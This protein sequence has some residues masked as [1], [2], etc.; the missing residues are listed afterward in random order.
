LSRFHE[1]SVARVDREADDAVSIT[2]AVPDDLREHYA[3]V[4]GQYVPIEAEIEGTALRRTYS[5][6]SPFGSRDLRVG[7]REVAGGAFSTFANRTLEPGMRLKVGVPMGRFTATPRQ[8][9][10]GTYVAFASGAGITPILSIIASLLETDDNS[11]VTLFFGNRNRNAIMFRDELEDLKDTFLD[12]FTLIHV[13]SRE[14]Q[15]VELLHGRLDAER[16]KTFARLGQFDVAG[17]DEYFL[18][19]P[20]DLIEN[21]TEALADLGVPN[22]KIR[23][24]RFTPAIPAPAAVAQPSPQTD[25]L[26]DMIEIEAR[27]DG[28]THRL[29]LL[30]GDET[31]IDAA[32]R[33]GIE[34]PYS[35]KGGMCCTCRAKLVEGDA[36]MANNYSLQPWELEAGFVLTC[37]LRPRSR[38]I[39]LDYDAV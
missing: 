3:F 9:G 30:P 35:C 27:L 8:D 4:P 21:A 32:H 37:Q 38:R 24:E 12:R 10:G 33:Q 6:C 19:G 18:C 22:E 5:I 34:L 20:G 7:I 29:E 25:K 1:L 14:G 26:A 17:T 16:I 2:F 23:R 15:D 28:A 36:V 13:L 39:V 31:I 11:Q